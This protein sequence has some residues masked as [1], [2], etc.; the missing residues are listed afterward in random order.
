LFANGTS[1][2]RAN[3]NCMA[4]HHKLSPRP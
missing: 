3:Q 4:Q 1:L 2:P